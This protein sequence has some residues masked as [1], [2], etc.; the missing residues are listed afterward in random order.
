MTAEQ[1][2]ALCEL[3]RRLG[4]EAQRLRDNGLRIDQKAR[5]DFVSEAD[6]YVEQELKVWLRTHRP[7][8]G[9]LGEESGLTQGE[10]GVWVI[11]PI[12]GTS[13]FILGMDY[14]CI[15]V[16]YV[17]QNRI[18]LGI[19]FAPDRDEFFFA[20]A[21]QGT[22]LNDQRLIVKEPSPDAVVIG[23]G[24]SSRTS[25]HSYV[26]TLEALL[27]KGIEYRR[28][29][30]GALMLAHVAAGQV[31]GYYEAHLNCWDALAGLLLIAEAGGVHNL[32]HADANL[33]QGNPVW[34]ACPEVQQRLTPLLLG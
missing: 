23:L 5:Q 9:F 25:A 10:E 15:S 3:I 2:R 8:D 34:A 33:L 30:A 14:W 31:H 16:A 26:Q 22:W 24:R 6:L 11:D 4:A 19:I 32:S 7:Q 27:D 1:Q 21:G 13:N 18:E 29:G 17:R 28:F 20:A 12:D